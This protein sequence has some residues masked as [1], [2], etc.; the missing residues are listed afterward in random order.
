[1]FG[2]R[3]APRGAVSLLA[4]RE[5][6]PFSSTLL[7]VSAG[8]GI[9][10]PSLI[11]NFSHEFYFTGNPDLRPEKTSSYEAGVVQ[12]W[13][14][15]RVRT[16]A[17][18]FHNS[19]RDLIAF[20]SLP[21]P[22]SGHMAEHRSQPGARRGVF[23]AREIERIH[24]CHGVLHAAVGP[25]SRSPIRRPACLRAWVKELSKR[26]PHS[27][28][29]ALSLAPRRW[30]LEIGAVLVGERQDTDFFGINR[31]PG[32]RNVYGALTL[33]LRWRR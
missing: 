3:F 14:G 27:G 30:S 18:L 5:H 17:A 16:E 28:S 21:P 23:R 1:M 7:R 6:G 9:T 33:N 22:V 8:R 29:V 4:A 32:Y 19:F 24:L 25:E 12:E 10:E 26:P 20:V 31:N 15:R 11:Q 2:G 13:F